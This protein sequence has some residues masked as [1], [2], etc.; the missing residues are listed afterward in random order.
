MEAF[1]PLHGRLPL[2]QEPFLYGVVTGGAYERVGLANEFKVL[3][4]LPP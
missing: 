3:P 2:P 1:L 4:K